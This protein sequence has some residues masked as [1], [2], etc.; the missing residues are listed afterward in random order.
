MGSFALSLIKDHLASF[1]TQKMFSASYSSRSSSKPAPSSISASN[2]VSNL[3]DIY[4]KKIS[5]STTCL[6]SLASILPLN[7]SAAFQSVSSNPMFPVFSVIY[8]TSKCLIVMIIKDFKYFTFK[9]FLFWFATY[10]IR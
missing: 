3:S 4:F 6:Y 1:G 8:F 2:F 9:A 7:L 10:P 5:P